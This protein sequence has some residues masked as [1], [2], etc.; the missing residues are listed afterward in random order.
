MT[1]LIHLPARPRRRHGTGVSGQTE[2]PERGGLLPRPNDNSIA[3]LDMGFS[4]GRF[5]REM[6]IVTLSPQWTFNSIQQHQPRVTSIPT[7]Y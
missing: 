7:G 5:I 4:T 6:C 1:D 3:A 2:P